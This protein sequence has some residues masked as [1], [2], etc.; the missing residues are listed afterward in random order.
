MES[1]IT[2]ADLDGVDVENDPDNKRPCGPSQM[3]D[4]NALTNLVLPTE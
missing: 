2:D 4:K 1:S 3:E